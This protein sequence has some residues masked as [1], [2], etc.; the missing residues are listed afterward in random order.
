MRRPITG[1]P[2]S[3]CACLVALGLVAASHTANASDLKPTQL[4]GIQRVN[5]W[6]YVD[7]DLEGFSEL[8]RELM[9]QAKTTLSMHGVSSDTSDTTSVLVEVRTEQ[10]KGC[11]VS[12][13]VLLTVGVNLSEQVELLR[14]RSVRMPGHN[15]AITW[16][17]RWTD[18]VPKSSLRQAIAEDVAMRVRELASDIEFA[19]RQPSP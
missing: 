10:V 6:V 14:D 7:R 8:E 12:D 18:V 3:Y 1:R 16:S 4:R 17:S 2:R 5:L 19:N 13:A 15:V 11:S 9:A